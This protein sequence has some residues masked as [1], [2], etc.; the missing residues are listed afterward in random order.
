MSLLTLFSAPK[1]FIDPKVA[2]IQ[3]NAIGS[4]VRL[5]DSPGAAD[6]G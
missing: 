6:G 1:P 4:W 2:L 3:E 5:P